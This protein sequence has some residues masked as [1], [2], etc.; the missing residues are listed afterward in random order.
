MRRLHLF[1]FG[2]QPWLPQVLREGETA[3]LVAAYRLVPLARDWAGKIVTT[4]HPGDHLEILDLCSGAG[5]A[6][7]MLIDELERRGCKAS[8]TLTDLYPNLKGGRHPRA[9][10]LGEPLDATRVPPELR[11]VRT[12]FSG[13]HHFRPEAARAILEDAFRR[14]RAI[15]IFESGSGTL[16]GVFTMLLVPLNVLAMMPLARPFRWA[17]LVFTYLIPLLPLIVFW[18][19]IVSML[20]IYSPEQ[21]R[22]LTEELKAPDYVWETGRLRVQGI[23][24]GLPYLIGRTVP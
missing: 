20:R 16:L 7:P 9:S 2:D 10:W 15:C 19:G 13:F 4:L 12:M 11:G 18:D 8:V 3:Y 6:I 17:Y 24:S 23:P 1:E 21:M 22:A 14:R 5:G